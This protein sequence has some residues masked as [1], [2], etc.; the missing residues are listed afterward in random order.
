M[1]YGGCDLPVAP[2][3]SVTSLDLSPGIKAPGLARPPMLPIV[4]SPRDRSTTPAKG[5]TH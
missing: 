3:T 4:A 1:F 5:C 2:A